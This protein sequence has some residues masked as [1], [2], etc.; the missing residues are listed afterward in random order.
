[1]K[2]VKFSLVG[3]IV[4]FVIVIVVFSKDYFSTNG[5]VISNSKSTSIKNSNSIT[6]M[7]ETEEG[8]GEY[9]VSS[10]I[11]WPTGDYI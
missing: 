11:E 9:Q 8:S 2:V 1:M 6:F 4:V 7:Y 3:L 5:K 10:D